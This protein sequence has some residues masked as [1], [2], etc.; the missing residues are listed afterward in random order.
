MTVNGKNF[1]NNLTFERNKD[2]VHPTRA[3]AAKWMDVIASF[4]M[5][6]SKYPIILK[7]PKNKAK[8]RSTLYLLSPKPPV[9]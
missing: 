8:K 2:G 1:E 9:I 6:K 7:T 5:K 3:S 4:I